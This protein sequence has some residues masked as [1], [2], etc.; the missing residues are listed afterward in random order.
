MPFSRCEV[1]I[2]SPELSATT[3]PKRVSPPPARRP[4]GPVHAAANPVGTTYEMCLALEHDDLRLLRQFRRLMETITGQFPP[5]AGGTLLFAGTGSSSHVAD[6]AGMIAKELTIACHSNVLLVDADATDRVLTQRFAADTEKGV[7][8]ALQDGVPATRF[9]VT[10]AVPRMAFLPF[11]ASLAARHTVA[12]QA[13]RDVV[14]EWK[15]AYRYT[16]I[17]GGSTLSKLTGWLSRF[18]DATYLV[19]QLGAADTQETVF[20]A[21][22]LT[23]AGARLMGSVATGAN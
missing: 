11:G 3:K 22:A 5:D 2:M 15:T 13:V 16:V 1:F 4:A 23:A 17:A 12:S 14:A 20:V 10:T 9:A 19:V 18:C 7:A 8:E 6:V 21:R